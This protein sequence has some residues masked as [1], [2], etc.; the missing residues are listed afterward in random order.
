MNSDILLNTLETIIGFFIAL[1]L[2]KLVDIF[3]KEPKQQREVLQAIKFEALANCNICVE[4]FKEYYEEGLVLNYFMLETIEKNISDPVFI[5]N[6]HPRDLQILM[7][8][9]RNTKLCNEY[10]EFVKTIKLSS[11]KKQSGMW[12]APAIKAWGNC[13]YKCGLS[14]KNVV[15]LKISEKRDLFFRELLDEDKTKRN[16]QQLA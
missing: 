11:D 7:D 1:L 12:D 10:S 9:L 3:W 2:N 14:I 5:S 15:D 8:Y 4:S 6:T 16:Y 13:I